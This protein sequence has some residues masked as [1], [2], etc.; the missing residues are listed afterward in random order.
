M[1]NFILNNGIILKTVAPITYKNDTTKIRTLV[2]ETDI[3][4]D[5]LFALLS[6]YNNICKISCTF[7]SG[8]VADI[9][10]DCA[11]LKLL[12]KKADGT[13]IAEL[14]TDAT[15]RL[16]QELQAKV[17]KVEQQNKELKIR[18][19]NLL[20]A[21]EEEQNEPENNIEPDETEQENQEE[22][23]NQSNTEVN[24]DNEDNEEN[25]EP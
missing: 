13:Y 23:Q 10:T 25:Q 3:P 15:E 1:Q 14:S 12:S 21:K 9:I 6:D 20:T 8:N 19:E 2:F 18:L 5:D 4:S 16:I 7:D 22:N 17:E 24:S 11:Q